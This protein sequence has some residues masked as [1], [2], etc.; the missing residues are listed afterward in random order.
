[1]DSNQ[2][3]TYCLGCR[4][5]SETKNRNIS[6]KL[7]LKAKRNVK[8]IEGTCSICGRKKSQKFTKLNE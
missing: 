5:Q 1:M 3:Q 8:N 4:H 6:E 2:K 7:K